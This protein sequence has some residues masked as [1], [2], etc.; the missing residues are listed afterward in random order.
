MRWKRWANSNYLT[1]DGRLWIARYSADYGHKTATRNWWT[2]CVWDGDNWN[3][4]DDV[5]GFAAAKK[6]AEQYVKEQS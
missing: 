6:L 2:L 4:V 1:E 3:V 5:K